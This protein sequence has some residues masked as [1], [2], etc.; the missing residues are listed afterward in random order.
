LRLGYELVEIPKDSIEMRVN[1]IL[2]K[3]LKPWINLN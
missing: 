3:L 2:D 1:F